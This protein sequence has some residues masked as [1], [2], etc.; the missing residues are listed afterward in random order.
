MK[1]NNKKGFTIVELVIVIAVIAILAAVL[2][3]TFSNVIEKAN[4]S[5]ALQAGKNAYTIAL[6]EELTDGDV[7]AATYYVAGNSLTKSE[8]A[9]TDVS[10]YIKL[11]FTANTEE[12]AITGVGKYANYTFSFVDGELKC[13]KN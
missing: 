2:I 4:T 10:D 7:D 12:P 1:R 9:P 13:V 8:T 3:P 11:V 5:A 6:A